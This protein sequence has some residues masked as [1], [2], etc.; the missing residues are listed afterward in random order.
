MSKHWTNE[1]AKAFQFAVAFDFLAELETA[2]KARGLSQRELAS[3]LGVSESRVSQ[4]LNNPGNL[5]LLSMVE[6]SRA[7]GMKVAVVPY[8]DGDQQNERG[9]VVAG[10]IRDCWKAMGKPTTQWEL[11]EAHQRSQ[12]PRAWLVAKPEPAFWVTND[13]EFECAA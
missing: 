2:M 7:V 12:G 4:I 3:R 10:I 9:P 6:L 13:N 8:D 5:T 11:D 1:E